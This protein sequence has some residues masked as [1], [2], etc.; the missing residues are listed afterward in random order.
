MRQT[1]VSFNSQLHWE[2]QTMYMLPV[3]KAHASIVLVSSSH[4]QSQGQAA[5]G[6]NTCF[7]PEAYKGWFRHLTG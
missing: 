3:E 5:H 7:S 2:P 6:R 1:K 4:M